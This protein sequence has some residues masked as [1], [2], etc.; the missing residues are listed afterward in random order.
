MTKRSWRVLSCA[1]IAAAL[2]SVSTITQ[3]K[4]Y[5]IEYDPQFIGP[6]FV[7]LPLDA[8]CL[9]AYPS[10]GT[11]AAGS[12]G[13]LNCTLNLVSADVTPFPAGTPHYVDTLGVT[14]YSDIASFIFIDSGALTQFDSRSP[15]DLVDSSCPSS[16][17]TCGAAEL[18]FQIG[19]GNADFPGV[20]TLTIGS[21]CFD[22]DGGFTPDPNLP[23]LQSDF[24]VGPALPE[25]GTLGLLL[26]GFGAGWL[27]RRRKAT[28]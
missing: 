28:A 4:I 18:N 7:D 27:A 13:D 9:P 8:L 26:G 16:F 23:V 2:A 22:C 19:G 14:N 11:V 5:P 6:A 3:A 10:G 1:F 25:P 17:G 12:G 15:I 21:W 24:V 20:A